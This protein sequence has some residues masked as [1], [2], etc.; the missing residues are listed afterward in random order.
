MRIIDETGKSKG[1]YISITDAKYID[2][3]RILIAFD[4]GTSRLVDFGDYLRHARHPDIRKYLDLMNF[5]KFKVVYGN[6]EWPNLEIAFPISELHRGKVEFKPSKDGLFAASASEALEATRKGNVP[7]LKRAL[8]QMKAR[9]T[10]K[11]VQFKHVKV[12]S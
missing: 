5:K 8:Q 11:I 9:S 10:K 2:E 6:L 3:Y 1:P 7:V 4:D 12:R